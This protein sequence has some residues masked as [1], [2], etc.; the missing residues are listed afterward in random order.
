MP[1]QHVHQW[2]EPVVDGP[3]ALTPR[4][5]VAVVGFDGSESAYRALDAAAQLISGRT[6]SIV[7]VYVA[8][9]SATAELSP[10]GVVEV[11]Q[12]FDA[13]EQQFTQVVRSRLTPLSRDGG[14][15]DVTGA[16]LTNLL[17]PPTGS[18]GIAVR[19][20]PSSSLSVAQCTPT[21]MSSHRYRSRW[22]VTRGTRF[23]LCH[24]GERER[25]KA[26]LAGGP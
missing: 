11:L 2:T 16:S 1:V 12:G 22:C 14:S 15:S 26:T 23:S 18:A 8:H 13:L 7:A 24:K 25:R 5:L 21:I 9:L 20:R 17:P 19:T 3:T 4:R 10:E 6:G